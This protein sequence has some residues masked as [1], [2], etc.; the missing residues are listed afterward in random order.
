MSQH[1]TMSP[2]PGQLCQR[3][4]GQKAASTGVA[5]GPVPEG[6]E[7]ISAWSLGWCS[8]E[9]VSEALQ[10]SPRPFSPACPPEHS[11]SCKG[12]LGHF[13]PCELLLGLQHHKPLAQ[14]L[15]R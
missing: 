15:T 8:Q 11:Q 3:L 2:R 14:A 13:A 6:Q 5:A 10:G 12:S 1:P 4:L 9:G 7:L